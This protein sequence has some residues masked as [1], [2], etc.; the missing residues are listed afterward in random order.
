MML[1]KVYCVHMVTW[2]GYDVLFQDVDVIWYKD[3]LP[4]FHA[5]D[6]PSVSGFDIFFQ[7]E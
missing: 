1:A 4:Y 3:P 6:D 2:L 5:N 7:D